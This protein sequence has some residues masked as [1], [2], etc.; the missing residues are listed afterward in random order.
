MKKLFILLQIFL[1]MLLTSNFAFAETYTYNGIT[2]NHSYS[3]KFPTDYKVITTGDNIQNFAKNDK[4]AEIVLT[5]K[6]FE[7]QTYSQAINSYL[8]KDT[9]LVKI[10]DFV[11]TSNAD[12]LA[13]KATYNGEKEFQI[14]F[15]K[16]GN[17]II[18]ITIPPAQDAIAQSIYDS[19]SFTDEWHQYID[20]DSKF[21]FIFPAGLEIK[22]SA[23]RVE[24]VKS[25]Q[26]QSEIF[27]VGIFKETSLEDAAEK[28]EEDNENLKEEKEIEFH[29][30]NKAILAIYNNEDINKKLGRVIV[31]NNSTSI[32]LTSVN[33]EDNFPHFNY[34]DE[35]V[36]EMLTSFEFFDIAGQYHAYLFFPDVRDNHPNAEAINDLSQSKVISGYPD[37]TFDPDGLIN[38]AELTKLVVKSKL[39]PKIEDYKDC[40]PDV[41]DQWFAPYI[42]YAKEKK[43][44]EGYKDNKFH[45][46]QNINRVEALKIIL[47]AFFADLKP[48]DKEAPEKELAKDIDQNGWYYE[49][50]HF[51]DSKSLLDKS[52][53]LLNEDG[54]YF[55]YPDKNITRKEVAETI[56]RSLKVQ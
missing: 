56:Y 21:T 17:L 12:L 8:D 7:G 18:S 20:F 2:K 16:R 5:V 31:E 24:L 45:P 42:C 13:K 55:Y 32:S 11:F 27:E 15:I 39:E 46:E 29:G 3:L 40:F 26:Y 9:E 30:I 4:T 10:E 51:A 44:V 28:A 25:G 22:N 37:G 41:K 23:D 34:Y 48:S 50:F 33:L 35:H 52:H 43:W 49:Y 19:F 53:V 1:L 14:T 36:L 47:N 6:E 38:R 54:T